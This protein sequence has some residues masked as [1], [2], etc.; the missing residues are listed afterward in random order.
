MID[1]NTRQKKAAKSKVEFRAV[2]FNR[3]LVVSLLVSPFFGSYFS[4]LDLA[5]GDIFTKCNLVL[6]NCV[7]AKSSTH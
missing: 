3:C 4:Q 1:I 5:F 2:V 6:P 7:I